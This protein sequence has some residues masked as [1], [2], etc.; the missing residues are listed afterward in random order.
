MIGEDLQRNWKGRSRSTTDLPAGT[1]A[2]ALDRL[3][4]PSPGRPRRSDSSK[5]H[6]TVLLPRLLLALAN[7]TNLFNDE[8]FALSIRDTQFIPP[9]EAHSELSLAVLLR[10]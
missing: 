5:T 2:N 4:N 8:I 7:K 3:D 9:R 10:R 1:L 6:P